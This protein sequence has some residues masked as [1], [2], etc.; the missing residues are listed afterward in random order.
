MVE[1]PYGPLIS[2][3]PESKQAPEI[4]LQ[5]WTLPWNR[6]KKSLT[7]PVE[8]AAAKREERGRQGNM[9][10]SKNLNR[11]DRQDQFVGD[12]LKSTGKAM[13]FPPKK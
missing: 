10:N 11:L 3:K 1:K 5:Q 7:K 13:H 4:W 12:Q 2:M 6:G 8:D 9:K